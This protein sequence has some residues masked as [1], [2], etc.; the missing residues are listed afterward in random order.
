MTWNNNTKVENGDWLSKPLPEEFIG[1][2]WR[3][4]V[5]LCNKDNQIKNFYNRTTKQGRF[6]LR[7]CPIIKVFNLIILIA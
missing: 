4:E 7:N 1:K 5:V 2:T 6:I 3:G